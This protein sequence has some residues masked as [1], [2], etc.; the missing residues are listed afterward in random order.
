MAKLKNPE[1]NSILF[2]KEERERLDIEQEHDDYIAYK[3]ETERQDSEQKAAAKQERNKLLLSLDP[4]Y[5][6]ELEG[7]RRHV[8]YDEH[9]DF[10]SDSHYVKVYDE[11]PKGA[12]VGQLTDTVYE[13]GAS[14]TYWGA[15]TS[16]PEHWSDK[17]AESYLAMRADGDKISEKL[18]DRYI[19]SNMDS[20]D[21]F[22]KSE[23]IKL[24]ISKDNDNHNKQSE[25]AR[26]IASIAKIT[27]LKKSQNEG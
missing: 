9:Y 5:N 4:E 23:K 13:G 20:I 19:K 16:V 22:L 18:F 26:S 11:L 24:R 2:D 25:N 7:N 1:I 21:N 27:R 12:Y 14:T 8:F 6:K 17:Q 15:S 10:I 3:Q